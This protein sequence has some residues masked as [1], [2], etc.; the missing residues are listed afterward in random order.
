M[1][2]PADR[3]LITDVHFS[4]KRDTWRPE[5]FRSWGRVFMCCLETRDQ[6]GNRKPQEREA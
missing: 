3:K 6:I 1:G 4:V 2:D 5:R